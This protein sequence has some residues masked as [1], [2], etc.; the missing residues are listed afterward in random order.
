MWDLALKEAKPAYVVRGHDKEVWS[1]AFHPNNRYLLSASWDTTV[2][3]WDF[4]TGNEVKTTKE[5]T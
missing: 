4:K 5:G 3:M 2:R 1:V